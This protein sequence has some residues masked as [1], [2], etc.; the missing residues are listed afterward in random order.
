M[1]L[2]PPP[3]PVPLYDVISTAGAT[4]GVIIV[5]IYT[6]INKVSSIV[7]HIVRVSAPIPITYAEVIQGVAGTW[8]GTHLSPCR[9]TWTYQKYKPDECYLM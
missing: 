9:T 3:L 6:A 5:A 4:W 7:G 1:A 2:L 8:I